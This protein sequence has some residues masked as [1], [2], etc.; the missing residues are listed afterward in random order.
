MK[1]EKLFQTI[2]DHPVELDSNLSQY[3]FAGG[4]AQA[5]ID[6]SCFVYLKA[7]K[8]PPIKAK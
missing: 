1:S 6:F 3:E 2:C 5:E 4:E 7:L 8:D